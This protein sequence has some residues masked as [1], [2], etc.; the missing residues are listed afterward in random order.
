MP[1]CPICKDQTQLV[2]YEGVKIHHCGRCGGY[3]LTDAKLD[4]ILARRDVVMPDAVKESTERMAAES[5]STKQLLCISCGTTMRKELFRGFTQLQIDACDRCGGIW[6]DRAELERCQVLWEQMKENPRELEK[7][8]K[9]GAV[10]VAMLAERDRLEDQREAF[11][12]L[13]RTIRLSGRHGLLGTLLDVL[14][15]WRR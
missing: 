14:M 15:V 11:D 1:R 7:R 5:N 2:P 4:L 8:A 10:E 6:F 3:W 12:S 9:Q 13:N